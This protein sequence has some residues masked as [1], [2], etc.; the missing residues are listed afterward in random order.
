[1]KKDN[2]DQE[3]KDEEGQEAQKNVTQLLFCRKVPSK[4]G[5]FFLVDFL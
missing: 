4:I 5:T 1:V 2:A 3:E